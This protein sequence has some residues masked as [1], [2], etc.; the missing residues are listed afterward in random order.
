MPIG[1][2]KLMGKYFDANGRRTPYKPKNKKEKKE[3]KDIVRQMKE[4]KK[5]T[6]KKE[7]INYH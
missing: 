6:I 5:T 3:Y 2:E 4:D 1:Y 7:G